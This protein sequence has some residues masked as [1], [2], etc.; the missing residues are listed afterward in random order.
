MADGA[1]T[2]PAGNASEIAGVVLAGQ[3]DMVAGDRLPFT[4]FKDNKRLF[5]NPGNSL[6]RFT[7]KVPGYRALFYWFVKFFPVLSRGFEIETGMSIH[8][9]DKNMSVENIDTEIRNRLI[10]SVSKP[11]TYPDGGKILKTIPSLFL[12]YKPMAYFKTIASVLFLIVVQFFI[13]VTVS[14]SQTGPTSRYP[15]LIVYG[16][17]AVAAIRSFFSGLILQN[18]RQK[19]PGS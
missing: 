17:A 12:N 5:H 14:H 10:G 2:Y 11:N 3:V 16:F 19:P 9:I 13:T 18:I 4:Y 1:D 15:T 8:T 7:I 6:V